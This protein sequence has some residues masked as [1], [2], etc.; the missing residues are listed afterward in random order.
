MKSHKEVLPF[1]NAI[2]Q[3]PLASPVLLP[4]APVPRSAPFGV[5]NHYCAVPF[6]AG[7]Q[8]DSTGGSAKATSITDGDRLVVMHISNIGFGSG[9]EITCQVVRLSWTT[10]CCRPVCAA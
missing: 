8:I 2:P 10:R 1:R 7:F 9:A 4:L 5:L 3:L 6:E